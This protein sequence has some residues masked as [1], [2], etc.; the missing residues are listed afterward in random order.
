MISHYYPTIMYQKMFKL[1]LDST[2]SDNQRF[3]R[4]D[5]SMGLIGHMGSD[6]GVFTA[7]YF[8]PLSKDGFIILMNR[9]IDDKTVAAMKRIAERL[10]QI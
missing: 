1:Q 8:N 3:F 10:K 5:N 2:I 6:F 4:S 7:Q 9:G